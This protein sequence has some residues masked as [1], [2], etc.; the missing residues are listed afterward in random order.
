[1]KPLRL[2]NSDRKIAG[3]CAAFANSFGLDA[4]IVRIIWACCVIIGGFGLLA[5]LVCWLV[6]PRE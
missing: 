3:V 1:M 5:Y 4:T 2:S 6:I